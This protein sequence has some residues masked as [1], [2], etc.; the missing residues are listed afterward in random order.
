MAIME[1]AMIVP[2][3][4]CGK[5]PSAD[6][7]LAIPL[8][9]IRFH[10]DIRQR[11]GEQVQPGAHQWPVE[12][13]QAGAQSRDS[14]ALQL[15]G[16]DRPAKIHQALLD[17]LE[18]RRLAPP[19]LGREVQDP[20][21]PAIFG[22]FVRHHRA[23]CKSAGPTSLLVVDEHGGPAPLELG[24][25]PLAHDPFCVDWVDQ[26]GA[27][28]GKEIPIFDELDHG[29]LS[30]PTLVGGTIIRARPGSRTHSITSMTDH[31][32]FATG[33]RSGIPR[34]ELYAT[35]KQFRTVDDGGGRG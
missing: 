21:F 22:D 28:A 34:R 35:T 3:S 6:R 4:F 32:S 11:G 8:R 26:A 10:Q 19:A 12:E 30:F 7:G 14:H 9:L 15:E 2:K 1:V 16:S 25:Q 13:A 33:N 20:E 31:A 17:V 27:T 23:D 5:L 18:L 24:G 29:S